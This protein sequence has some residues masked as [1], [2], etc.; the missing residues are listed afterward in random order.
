MDLNPSSTFCKRHQH[1]QSTEVQ[2]A[3]SALLYVDPLPIFLAVIESTTVL[4]VAHAKT[5]G[6]MLSFSLLL[7]LCNESIN[8]FLVLPP[9]QDVLG[10]VLHPTTSFS[11][12]LLSMF[13][14]T[15][16]CLDHCKVQLGALISHSCPFIFYPPCRHRDPLKHKSSPITPL[17]KLDDCHRTVAHVICSLPTSLSISSLTTSFF[18]LF[19]RYAKLISPQ[20]LALATP[21]SGTLFP[22][23]L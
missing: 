12:C 13:T 19:L 23:G 2:K 3:W 6:V 5:L 1:G 17:L 21:L 20:G 11:F 7:I 4:L 18:L 16:S 8:K 9:N 14:W 22:P 10:C 15:F